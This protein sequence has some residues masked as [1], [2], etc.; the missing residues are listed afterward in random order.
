M[1]KLFI[2]FSRGGGGSFIRGGVYFKKFQKRGG[3]RLLE[4]GG[5]LIV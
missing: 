5:R 2:K 4:G 3:G 1:A